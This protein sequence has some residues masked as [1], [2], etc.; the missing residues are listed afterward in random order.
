MIDILDSYR[1]FLGDGN[2]WEEFIHALLFLRHG[3]ANYAVVPAK[4]GG[5]WGLDGYSYDGHAYQCYRAEDCSTAELYAHQRKKMTTDVGKFI[6][7]RP[8]LEVALAAVVPIKRWCFVVPSY[9][10]SELLKHA[11]KKSKQIREA[12]LPYASADII[13]H[14]DSL[15]AFRTELVVY[16]AS[17]S[18]ALHFEPSAVSDDDVKNFNDTQ[19]GFIANLH[20]KLRAQPNKPTAVRLA[21]QAKALMRTFIQFESVKDALHKDNPRAYTEIMRCGESFKRRLEVFGS[22]NTGGADIL[23]TH[24]DD[25]VKDIATVVS[26]LS[27]TNVELIGEGYIAQF[28]MDCTMEI[29]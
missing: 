7:N 18:A 28:L 2:D 26:S 20:R 24:F 10:S 4:H 5:D 17:A 9:T 15:E 16:A 23:K 25:L 29:A 6:A 11:S 3:S 8:D 27:R 12:S 19:T 22:D 21:T 1:P 14:V 13:V